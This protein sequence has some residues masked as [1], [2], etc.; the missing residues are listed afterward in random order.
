M[1]RRL[2]RGQEGRDG[3]AKQGAGKGWMGGKG[4]KVEGSASL[5]FPSCL[6]SPSCPS[7]LVMQVAHLSRLRAREECLVIHARAS[8]RRQ[9]P[10]IAVD[11]GKRHIVWRFECDAAVAGQGA[12]HELRP[13]G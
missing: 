13:D 9:L 8:W 10:G 11:I 12:G 1:L 2:Y 5:S 4:W 3:Q 7:C 6:A